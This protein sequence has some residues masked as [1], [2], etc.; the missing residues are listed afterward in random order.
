MGTLETL[1]L[2]DKI[3]DMLVAGASSDEIKIYARGQGMETLREN[4]LRQFALGMT[5]LEEVLRV[6]AEE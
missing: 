4:A 1:T 6:T 3:R 5:T 2:D